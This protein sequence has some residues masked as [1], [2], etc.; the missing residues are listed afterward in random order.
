MFRDRTHAGLELASLLEGGVTPETLVLAIPAGGVPVAVAMAR[1]LGLE[2]DLAIVSKITLPWNTESGYGA[3]AFDG[4]VLLNE[5][6]LRELPLSKEDVEAG[7]ARTRAKVERRARELR[8][9]APPLCVA[10]R[11]VLLVDDGL[12]SGFT[13]RAAVAAA[14]SLGAESVSLAV[15]T[16]HVRAIESLIDDVAR[17]VCANVR[18]G[19]SFAVAEAYERWVDVSEDEVKALLAELEGSL[20]VGRARER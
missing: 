7:I 14:R 4:S 5:A 6:Y 10:G 16:G 15:P 17:L 1:P 18:G 2:L 13:M 9:D 20:H 11:D 8:G 12:A 3:V 19:Y